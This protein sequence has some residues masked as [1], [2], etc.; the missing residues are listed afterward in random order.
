MSSFSTGDHQDNTSSE[1]PMKWVLEKLVLTLEKLHPGKQMSLI[2]DNAPIITNKVSQVLRAL[3][4]SCCWI[5]QSNRM[6]SASIF[7][8]WWKEEAAQK[9][10][11]SWVSICGL[12]WTQGQWAAWPR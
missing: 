5:W 6:L 11:T 10:R 7:L 9:E 1:T 8:R 12:A 3:Q 2:H 4:K